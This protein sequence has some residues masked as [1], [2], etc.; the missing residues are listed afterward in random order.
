MSKNKRGFTLIEIIVVIAVIAVLTGIVV[1]VVGKILEEAKVSK[2]KTDVDTLSKAIL[3]LYK[4][5]AFWPNSLDITTLS[6]WNSG[7]NGLLSNATG[8]LRY[9][10]WKG[11]YLVRRVTNDPWGSPYRYRG[12]GR[13]GQSRTRIGDRR[14]QCYG[15]NRANNSASTYNR[16][17]SGGDDIIHFFN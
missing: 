10:D 17:Q 9:P 15:P 16:R 11:P 1:P 8:R 6:A 7:A 13:T 14:I 5:T 2:A 4:D 3:S 12:G